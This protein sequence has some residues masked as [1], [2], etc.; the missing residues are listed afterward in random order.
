MYAARAH[1]DDT[2][3][4][5]GIRWLN[6]GW[7]A[8]PTVAEVMDSSAVAKVLEHRAS[9]GFNASQEPDTTGQQ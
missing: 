5:G 1:A 2:T 8:V 4:E 3:R 7:N 6:E 9:F